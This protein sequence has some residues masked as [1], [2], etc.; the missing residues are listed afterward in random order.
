VQ[1]AFFFTSG[2]VLAA[3]HEGLAKVP[4]RGEFF[5]IKQVHTGHEKLDRHVAGVIAACPRRPLHW[6][7]CCGNL[8]VMVEGDSPTLVVLDAM[9]NHYVLQ[10]AGPDV[11]CPVYVDIAQMIFSIYCHPRF[12]RSILQSADGFVDRF[13]EGYAHES[14]QEVDR[15]TAL[16]CAVELTSMCQTHQEKQSG[17]HAANLRDRQ[18]REARTSL[19]KAAAVKALPEEEESAAS[20]DRVPLA[21]AGAAN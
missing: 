16:A 14:K 15:A 12:T 4:T 5:P 18:F 10:E 13:L 21:G 11:V 9:P 1:D 3:L 2:R 17:D 8:F 6:D 20:A 19:L 7:Y